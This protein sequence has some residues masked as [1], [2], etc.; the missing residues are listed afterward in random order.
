MIDEMKSLEKEKDTG[1]SRSPSWEMYSRLKMG[2]Y[3]KVQPRRQIDTEV[4]SQDGG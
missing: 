3:L 2:V 4:Q 1:T